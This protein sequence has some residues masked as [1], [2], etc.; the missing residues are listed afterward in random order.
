MSS[1]G[2]WIWCNS[3]SG[4]LQAL[5]KGPASTAV[6]TRTLADLHH[7]CYL[8]RRQVEQVS[9]AIFVEESALTTQLV[10]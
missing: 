10:L 9:V 1:S 7:H 8:R 2:G 3:I 6:L 5:V 4:T